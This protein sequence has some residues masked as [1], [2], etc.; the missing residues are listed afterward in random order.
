MIHRPRRNRRTPGI[1]QSLQ[2][3]WLRKEDLVY[4][5]FITEERNTKQ[6]IT[7]M[8]GQYRWGLDSMDEVLDKAFK[9]GVQSFALFPVIND[10]KKDKTGTYST[11]PENVLLKAV[12]KIKEINSD[13]VLY[14]DV[15]LDPYSS[16]G[17]DG[18][19]EEGKV[20]NDETLPLLANMALAQAKAGAD[21]ISPS[22]MMDGRIGFIRQTLDENGFQDT[23]ILSYSAKYASSFYG[24]FREALDSAPRFGDKKTYQMNPANRIEATRELALDADE[25]ADILMIKPAT[26]YLDIIREAKDRFDIPIAA[27]NVS[28]EYSMIKAAA[29]KGWMDEKK[30]AFESLLSI[31][32]AGADLIFTYWALDIAQ[33][34]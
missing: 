1:R 32:R 28:G 17:H 3:T 33:T 13:S 14:T 20:L 27:Y 18:L 34:L 19:V 12:K 16:D 11:N 15:A 31:K 2:E 29:A 25:G 26:L 21:Y 8:P 10:S 6:E 4:P 22:D 30:A 9:L 5:L 24:P 23:G 7:A